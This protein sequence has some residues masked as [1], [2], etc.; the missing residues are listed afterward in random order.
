[1]PLLLA[2][3]ASQ[4]PLLLA[5]AKELWL[6]AVGLFGTGLTLYFFW[7]KE[8]KEKQQELARQAAEAKAAEEAWKKKM[9]GAVGQFVDKE[10]LDGQ[11]AKLGQEIG[12]NEAKIKTLH[13]RGEEVNNKLDM[14]V[15]SLEQNHTNLA[16]LPT[17]FASLKTDH[18]VLASE[19]RQLGNSI[20]R[21]VDKQEQHFRDMMA[22]MQKIEYNNGRMD[23][24]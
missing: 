10:K 16:G 15:S 8:Q 19:V 13:D 20:E 2:A 4:F 5:L 3:T 21:L 14:R 1:M 12:Q 9:E 11:F 24:K 23:G 18:A 17:Q 6:L 7:R 22:A